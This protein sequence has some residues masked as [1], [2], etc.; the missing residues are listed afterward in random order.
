M[1]HEG[2]RPPILPSYARWPWCWDPVERDRMELANVA[3][4]FWVTTKTRRTPPT[5]GR[6]Y[7]YQG[8][9]EPASTQ[10]RGLRTSRR[11]QC[12]QVWS[13]RTMVMHFSRC[14]SLS[15]KRES[16]NPTPSRRIGRRPKISPW[17]LNS[18]EEV[19]TTTR[20]PACCQSHSSPAPSPTSAFARRF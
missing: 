20:A 5:R 15:G 19:Q 11:R 17:S 2:A 14:R 12:S 8:T 10:K 18:F 9:A 4:S 13:V 3:I 7:I 6:R 1:M 16:G